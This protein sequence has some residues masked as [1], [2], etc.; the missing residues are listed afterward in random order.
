MR[1]RDEA[2]KSFSDGAL[3]GLPQERTGRL[4]ENIMKIHLN[5]DGQQPGPYGL[6]EINSLLATGRLRLDCWAWHEGLDDWI[7]LS[8]VAGIDP[9]P[10]PG[11]EVYL[12]KDGQRYGPYAPEEIEKRLASGQL[13]LDDYWA[14]DDG[15]REWIP[16]SQLPGLRIP[17]TED[18]SR[19]PPTGDR[20]QRNSKL[21][22][23]L[24]TLL[25]WPLKSV[26]L[27]LKLPLFLL[28]KRFFRRLALL[29][30]AI[31]VAGLGWIYLTLPD[32]ERID[33]IDQGLEIHVRK[34][35]EDLDVLDAI[36]NLQMSLENI[37]DHLVKAILASEDRR[38]YEHIGI[39]WRGLA[40]AGVGC[41][42]NLIRLEIECE[43]GGSTITQQLVKLS[44]F[45]LDR[46]PLR[47]IKEILT[48]LQ[49]ERRYD[50]NEIL[51]MYLNRLPLGRKVFG[52]EVAARTHFH[53]HAREL[54][55]YESAIIAGAITRPSVNNFSDNPAL[56]L[57]HADKILNAMVAAGYLGEAEKELAKRQGYRMGDNPWKPIYYRDFWQWIKPAL[58]ERIGE[59]DGAYI[60]IT[61]LNSEL[62]LY[63]ERAVD[64]YLARYAHLDVHQGALIAMNRHGGVLAM[65][66]GTGRE[67]HGWNRAVQARRQPGSVFKPIV[68]LAALERGW[69]IDQ[70]VHDAP[71]SCGNWTPEN[72]DERYLGPMSLARSL[73][74]SRN[75]VAVRLSK[76]IGIDKI[77][78]TA[79]RLGITAALPNECA[80]ALGA[81][82]LSLLEVVTAYCVLA[83]GG[84]RVEAYGIIGIRDREGRFVFWREPHDGKQVVR[85]EHVR[86]LSRMLTEAVTDGT[87]RRAAL[88]R[89][90][91]A[92]K[93]G[94]TNDY[95][96]AW[97]V[98]YTP[99]LT[100][101]VWVGNDDNSPM[102]GVTGGDLPA[103]IFRRL[104]INAYEN[105]AFIGEQLK[106][107][108]P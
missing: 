40:R 28:R 87:G 3:P 50:K 4:G 39:S 98:G 26:L 83:N 78:E 65:V 68:Y 105:L 14:W 79:R 49:V 70:T 61:S 47:K 31:V 17:E 101:G 76:E 8:Q 96:D 33:S 22:E 77:A 18:G 19:N 97:F 51:T 15:V 91:I 102:R 63:A 71:V 99:S 90:V 94:T 5:R 7:P 41:L 82:E 12:G 88:D 93:T 66:G 6:D 64:T 81:K 72:Y 44:F 53:K 69:R 46:S 42:K 55:L 24:V 86:D 106:S 74:L 35:G 84:H 103:R 43:A 29:A 59:R 57:R 54:N 30:V 52:V 34:R 107:F 62:Q 25:S 56:A 95:R 11:G 9:R 38:F 108:Y 67:D 23:T 58:L 27:L 104:T 36:T 2:F 73:A 32:I 1:A 89:T 45:H 60:V 48:A 85:L 80:V 10:R 37:P 20:D 21:G 100:V 92:G 13:E 16:L 75:T